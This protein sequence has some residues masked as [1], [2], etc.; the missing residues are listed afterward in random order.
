MKV[1][2]TNTKIVTLKAVLKVGM[3]RSL[4]MEIVLK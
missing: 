2:C 3:I 4:S 1:V